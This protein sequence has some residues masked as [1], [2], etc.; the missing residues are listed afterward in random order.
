MCGTSGENATYSTKEAGGEEMMPKMQFACDKCGNPGCLITVQPDL[1]CG[2]FHIC[3]VSFKKRAQWQRKNEFAGDDMAALEN[4]C[5][6]KF[7]EVS[8]NE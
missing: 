8:G 5:R 3:P 1:W 7:P 2:I 6:K 4:I